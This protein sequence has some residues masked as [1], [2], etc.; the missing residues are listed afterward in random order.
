VGLVSSAGGG[1]SGTLMGILCWVAL[2]PLAAAFLVPALVVE[3]RGC[4]LPA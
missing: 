4:A 2:A 1:A 3:T